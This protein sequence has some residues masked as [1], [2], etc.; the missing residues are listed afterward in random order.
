MN[1]LSKNFLFFLS[2][3][4]CLVTSDGYLNFN[5]SV[6]EEVRNE[7]VKIY[8]DA[9]EKGK[10]M[11]K[12]EYKKLYD[13]YILNQN[14]TKVFKYD[15]GSIK[16][17]SCYFR[18]LEFC[19]DVE[20]ELIKFFVPFTEFVAGLS[21]SQLR[22]EQPRYKH[23]VYQTSSVSYYDGQTQLQQNVGQKTMVTKTVTNEHVL[24]LRYPKITGDISDGVS[25][26]LT[27]EEIKDKEDSYSAY[28]IF[29]IPYVGNQ[30]RY[31]GGNTTYS[32]EPTISYPTEF[33][34]IE[35]N[36]MGDYMGFIL[37]RNGE[38]IYD[39]VNDINLLSPVS[40]SDEYLPVKTF[41]PAYPRRAQERGIEGYVVVSF[42]VNEKGNVENVSI[43]EGKCGKNND[44]RDCSIFNSS[45][46]RAAEKFKYDP[47]SENGSPIKTYDVSYKLNFSISE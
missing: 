40:A 39:T 29:S 24:T 28:L 13:S 14:K 16:I 41:I 27:I 33:Q 2:F 5:A 10:Y 3:F 25:L 26:P 38:A 32:K 34:T 7:I 44:F 31:S 9:P 20:E 42:T 11:K 43:V 4:S 8:N 46:K 23:L 47:K 45:A 36:L 12:A 17:G 22:K 6:H 35:Y 21:Y 15:I 30:I 37:E 18:S 1:F 19:Y